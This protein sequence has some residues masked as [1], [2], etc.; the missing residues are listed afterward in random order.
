MRTP[1]VLLAIV[2]CTQLARADY[3]FG[4]SPIGPLDASDPIVLFTTYPPDSSGPGDAVEVGFSLSDQMATGLAVE[5]ASRDSQGAETVLLNGVLALGQHSQ[6]L[7]FAAGEWSLVLRAQD[8]FGNRDEL[9]GAV[10]VVQGTSVGDPQM[11][12]AFGLEQPAP[13]PFNPRTL[14]N[15]T[16][17]TAGSATLEVYNL[18]GQVVCSLVDGWLQAGRHETV[19]DGSALPSGVY[20]ARLASGDEWATTRLTLLK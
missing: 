17:P 18:R 3:A 8:D 5:L 16:L 15:F 6:V 7:E 9:Q 11:P 2:L 4:L 1:C 14:L 12:L 19:F 13:N 20:L 10:F